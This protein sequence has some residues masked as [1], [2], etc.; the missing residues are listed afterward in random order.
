MKAVK[1][2]GVV[3]G[4]IVALIVVIVV[5]ALVGIDQAAKIGIERGATYALG[6]DTTLDSA[7]I[8]VFSGEFGMSGL[9][10]SNPDGYTSPHFLSLG[11]GEVNVS[12][13]SLSS[14][15]ITLP[16]LSLSTID[17]HLDKKDGSSNYQTILDNLKRFETSEEP[18]PADTGQESQK[19]VI[20]ELTISDITV[21]AAVVGS[22]KTTAKVD[23]ITLKNVGSGGKPVDMGQLTGVI[24]KSL[25]AAA[26]TAGA[27]EFPAAVLGELES[28]LG[29]LESLGDL[30]V[31]VT[32]EIGGVTQELGSLLGD[33][34]EGVG[35]TLDDVGGAVEDAAKGIGDLFG[36]GDDK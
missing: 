19:F 11:T 16:L 20:E 22:A 10:V 28:G 23:S 27:E 21:H 12:Y 9:T 36:G 18:P 26:I 6:V 4:A 15:L 14:D 34:G 29:G 3:V 5:L 32:A 2:L 33:L 30:G 7:D 25:M 35:E 13:E 17:V 24:I 1:I 8:G 31:S